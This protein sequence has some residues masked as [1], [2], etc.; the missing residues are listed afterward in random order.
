MCGISVWGNDRKSECI[1]VNP[2]R[3][4]VF[5]GQNISARKLVG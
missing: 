4:E 1:S 2:L 3:A 5:R